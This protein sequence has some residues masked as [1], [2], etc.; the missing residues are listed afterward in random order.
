VAVEARL[1]KI[2]SDLGWGAAPAGAVRVTEDSPAPSEPGAVLWSGTIVFAKVP[3]PGTFRVVVREFEQ[4]S[5]DAP[6][7]SDGGTI[8]VKRLVYATRFAYDFPTTRPK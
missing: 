3:P 7:T 6:A 2:T 4:L 1:P 8:P 5:G